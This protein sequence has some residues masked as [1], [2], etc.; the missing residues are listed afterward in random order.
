MVPEIQDITNY[1]SA[2]KN[3]TIR[4]VTT[5]DIDTLQAISR[6]TFSETFSESNTAED[7]EKYLEESFSA[8]KLATEVSNEHSTFYFAATDQEIIGYMKLNTG[9]AQTELQNKNSL[10]IERIYVL[11]EHQGQKAGQQLYEEALKVAREKNADYI[12]LGVWE[13]NYKAIRFYQKNGF[14]AFDQHIFRLGDDVQTD[15]MMRK[16]L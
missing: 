5:E 3:I 8:K 4:K 13:E 2:M 14:A 12:W 9:R 7:M 6:Q 11:N 1:I 16:I 15:I 10:E